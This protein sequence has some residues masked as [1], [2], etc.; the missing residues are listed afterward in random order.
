[1]ELCVSAGEEICDFIIVPAVIVNVFSASVCLGSVFG[2][3]S[4][5]PETKTKGRD[6]KCC[7]RESRL[8]AIQTDLPFD[9]VLRCSSEKSTARKEST[10]SPVREGVS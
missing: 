3:R 4:L 2:G 10:R 6:F 5:R 8:D 1:M 7:Y 9:R